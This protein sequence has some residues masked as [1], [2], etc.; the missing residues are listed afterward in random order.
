MNRSAPAPRWRTVINRIDGVVTPPANA[1][2]R[3]N[4]FA[5]LIAATTRLE[6]QLRRRLERQTARVWHLWNLPTASD[7]RRISAQLAVIEARLRDLA[8]EIEERFEHD[9]DER[10]E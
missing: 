5:D 7:Q 3:T 4:L 10:S 1:F 6:S 9:P 2:V 8:E